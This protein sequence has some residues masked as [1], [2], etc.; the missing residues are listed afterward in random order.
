VANLFNSVNYPTQVPDTLTIGDRFVWKRT[1]MVADYP[2]ATYQVKYSFR[3]LSSAATEIAIT[4]TENS[5]PDEYIVEVGSSTTAA[6]TAG[7]YTYQEY[8]VRSS[9]SERI[10]YSTG[11]IKL[12]PNLDADTSD[13]RSSARKILD[14]LNAMLENRASIDQMSMSIAGRSLS[15]MTPAEIRDWQQ[16]YQYIVSKETK[17]MR[18]KKG[19]PTGS[20]IKVKF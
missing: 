3:L 6:Y 12:E 9:D 15:R 16:H 2:I 18:I 8:V 19:Q 13:P 10:V 11:I 1:A 7:D 20:E 14:G 5:D 17:K 4:A